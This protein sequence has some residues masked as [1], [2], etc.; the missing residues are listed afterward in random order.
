MQLPQDV[1]DPATVAEHLK[2]INKMQ[3][4]WVLRFKELNQKASSKRFTQVVRQA[5][6]STALRCQEDEMRRQ[7]NSF[8]AV[9]V[10]ASI[11][12]I[13]LATEACWDGDTLSYTEACPSRNTWVVAQWFVGLALLVLLVL[14][15]AVKTKSETR[16][17]QLASRWTAFFGTRL[18]LYFLLEVVLIVVLSPIPTSQLAHTSGL[19]DLQTQLALFACLLRCYVFVRLLRDYSKVY[20]LRHFYNDFNKRELKFSYSNLLRTEFIKHAAVMILSITVVLVTAMAYL[21]HVAERELWLSDP[22]SALYDVITPVYSVFSAIEDKTEIGELWRPNPLAT[23]TNCV[24]F[25]IQSMSTVG[26]ARY[27]PIGVLGQAYAAVAIG[28]GWLLIAALVGTVTVNLQ[29]DSAHDLA[30]QWTDLKLA[31]HRVRERAKE[32]IV[33]KYRHYKK[34]LAKKQGHEEDYLATLGFHTRKLVRNDLRVEAKLIALAFERKKNACMAKQYRARYSHL[35][36]NSTED[37]LLE[38]DRDPVMLWSECGVRR[39]FI[40]KKEMARAKAQV[41]AIERK[42]AADAKNAPPK[43]LVSMFKRS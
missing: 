32:E 6:M 20:Q 11:V 8:I 25:A 22:N 26:Q 28:C 24:W 43:N 10:L 40:S 33:L 41:A 21:V 3:Q 1:T 39:T 13:L 19:T 37:K 12:L 16:K 14:L 9:L 5:K 18:W 23:F 42:Q 2:T 30:A 29:V 7:I 15:Y 36:K 35:M 4:A 31:Q 34:K 17:H 38:D 27:L